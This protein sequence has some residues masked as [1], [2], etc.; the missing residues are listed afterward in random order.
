MVP[1]R[2]GFIDV[3][4]NNPDL[5]GPLWVCVTL[6]VTASMSGNI[7]KYFRSHGQSNWT[8]HFQ[9]VTSLAT[10]LFIYTWIV[11][12]LLW[13]VLAWRVGQANTHSLFS[14]ITLYGYSLSI[15]IPVSVLWTVL[16]HFATLQ[17]I[18]TVA[19]A[20]L[21]GG[22]L[23]IS[24]WPVIKRD[25]QKIAYGVIAAIV[26]L[27]LVLAVG[28]QL[29]FFRSVSSSP[30]VI[31]HSSGI[32]VSPNDVINQISAQIDPTGAIPDENGPGENNSGQKHIINPDSKTE[33]DK[34]KVK[35]KPKTSKSIKERIEVS[36]S[37][38][39]GVVKEAND[40]VPSH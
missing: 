31:Q 15:Y 19:A 36:S 34:L 35:I 24:F 38:M 17:W 12:I 11:P 4:S 7:A 37:S 9:E 23:A 8:F 25:K 21:S 22:V 40:P 26:L 30:Q 14:M 32:N 27:H 33:Q 20:T 18:I 2:K 16:I 29:Y 5:Y 28:F 3:I 13:G 39:D 6:I 1:N 10:I